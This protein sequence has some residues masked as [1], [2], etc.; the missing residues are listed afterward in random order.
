MPDSSRALTSDGN[1]IYADYERRTADV[2]AL[3][4]SMCRTLGSKSLPERNRLYHVAGL[5][6]AL[7]VFRTMAIQEATSA[8]RARRHRDDRHLQALIRSIRP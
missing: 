4:D 6:R 8:W 7:W 5:A 1:D 3:L 2:T